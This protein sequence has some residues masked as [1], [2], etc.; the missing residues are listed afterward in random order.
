MPTERGCAA[1]GSDYNQGIHGLE[2]WDMTDTPPQQSWIARNPLKFVIGCVGALVVVTMSL[3]IG[4]ICFVLYVMKASDA[5]QLSLKQVQADSRVQAE[6]GA[7]I[8][9]GWYVLGNI[10]TG[11]DGGNANIYYPISGSKGS[12][13]VQVQATKNMGTW[14]FQKLV[15]TV[16]GQKTVVT[17]I[18]AG[19]TTGPDKLTPEKPT[20]TDGENP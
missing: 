18:P 14:S 12:G 2:N 3:S 16:D 20:E 4:I 19:S 10:N 11:G 6:L 13:T 1:A 9:D 5:F 15:V 7:P 8:K 17:L